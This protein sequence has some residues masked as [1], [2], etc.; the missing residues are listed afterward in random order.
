MLAQGRQL[1]RRRITVASWGR[2]LA[3]LGALI[4]Y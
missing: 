1:T 2:P 4:E 3:N